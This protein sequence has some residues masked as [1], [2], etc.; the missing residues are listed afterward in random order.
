MALLSDLA[1]SLAAFPGR[2]TH[3]W[4]YDRRAAD[5]NVAQNAELARIGRLYAALAQ[6]NQAIVWAASRQQLFDEVCRLLTKVAGF[7]SARVMM[8]SPEHNV[9]VPVAENGDCESVSTS[10]ILPIDDSPLGQGPSVTAFREDRPYIS[11]D[12]QADLALNPILSQL[13]P[14]DH[15]AG[16]I[17]PIRMKHKVCGTLSVYAGQPN[18]FHDKEI[19]LLL[20]VASDLSFA[21]DNFARIEERREAEIR[22]QRFATIIA[23]T[24]D[25]IISLDVHGLVT[26][27]NAGAEAIF[28]YTAEEMIGRRAAELV[29][30]GRPEEERRVLELIAS[31]KHLTQHEMLCIRKDGQRIPVSAT[32]SPLRAPRDSNGH[33][34]SSTQSGAAIPTEIIGATLIMRDVSEHQRIT[35][36]ALREQAFSNTLL[37]NMPGVLYLFNSR[38]RYLRWNRNLQTATGY[39]DDE[40]AKLNPL[41][42]F[43]DVDK[44][45]IEAKIAEVF[46]AGH[47]IIEADLIDR[48]GNATPYFFTGSRLQFDGEPCLVGMGIDISVLRKTEAELADHAARLQIVS[49]QLL[50]VQENER[51]GLARDLHD[52]VGQELTAL[53]LNL[54]F[55]RDEVAAAGLAGLDTRLRD[56]LSLIETT[57]RHL[58]DIM[59]ELRP[60]GLDEL[61]L[62]A[63][64]KEHAARVAH[65]SGLQLQIDGGEPT[66]RLSGTLAIA[67]FRIAQEAMNNVV[68]HAGATRLSIALLSDGTAQLLSIADDGCGFDPAYRR[69][70]GS[71][72]MGMTT[73]RERAEAVGATLRVDSRPGMGTR[74]E[75]RFAWPPR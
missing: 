58:R 63:A 12:L 41:A 10:P 16:A 46:A 17:F 48:H 62:L 1:R 49:R 50:D 72:G 19:A 54:A 7:R 69:P 71:D 70:A 52:S 18:F 8:F 28:G 25:A 21:L 22:L 34:R 20:N 47:G 73:M 6:V 45:R 51:R 26:S 59:V 2:V 42:F 60:P 3:T 74:V 11:N 37:A 35:A 9:L 13:R 36:N 44:P 40:I 31:G 75:V 56:S 32:A 64:L 5:A 23:S 68:K 39:R 55:I 67:L 27:W 66:P 53:S 30:D 14:P 15:R 61:G 57:S 33:L 38:G 29:A 4:R 65:R 43:N 24:D